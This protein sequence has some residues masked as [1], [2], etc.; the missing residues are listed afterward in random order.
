MYSRNLHNTYHNQIQDNHKK[1]MMVRKSHQGCIRAVGS[2]FAKFFHT[3]KHICNNFP[4]N[5]KTRHLDNVT[6][7][8]DGTEVVCHLQQH[9]YF[10][11]VPDIDHILHIITANFKVEQPPGIIFDA[12]CR[13][14]DLTGAITPS[15]TKDENCCSLNNME[16][17]VPA[18]KTATEDIAELCCQGRQLMMIMSQYLEMP[19]L[20]LLHN[21]MLENG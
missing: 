20:H 2:V 19:G 9:C 7:I 8:Q 17:N 13:A 15:N 5:Y 10:C 21:Q 3:S 12:E 1:A 6:I 11:Y 16:Q 18:S 14:T 4:N